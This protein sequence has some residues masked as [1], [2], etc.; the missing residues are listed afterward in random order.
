MKSSLS[1]PLILFGLLAAILVLAIAPDP[2]AAIGGLVLANAG[3]IEIE[4]LKKALTDQGAA[5]KEYFEKQMTMMQEL[6]VRQLDVE[7]KLAR[8]PMTGAADFSGNGIGELTKMIIGSSGL[9]AFQK[10]DTPSVS[11]KVPAHLFKTA[12]ANAVGQNQPLV[13]AD[14]QPGIVF[15]PQR[16]FTIR[17]LFAQIPT[18]SNLVEFCRELTFTNAAAPQYDSSSPTPHAEGAPKAESGMTFELDSEAVITVAHWIPASRQVLADAPQL[19]QH[20]GQR[21]LYGLKL[22]E[23]DEL[24]NSA[25]A[26]G[27][28]NGLINQ[29]AAFTGGA[30]NQSKIDT[31]AKAI[32]QLILTDYEPSGFILNPGDWWSIL[33]LKDSQGR[34]L[35]GDPGAMREPRLWGLPVVATPTMAAGGF[36]AL[37][38]MRAGFI[39]DREDAVIR[40]SEHHADF[41]IKN[42]V[43]ILCEERL[44]LVIQRTGALVYGSLNFA[45]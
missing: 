11:I 17:D 14:R 12:V 44:A 33:M 19:E 23:E 39:A 10:G 7:Q 37:D 9:A 43:A 25:G 38:A 5:V 20:V 2:A 1:Y 35:F 41:F 4:V 28:L 13:P 27:E 34:Y 18:G 15:G 8:K 29:A 6:K 3:G 36:L 40:I 42:L 22:E 32:V 24:L 45:G 16:R 26:N 31:L 30:T 21:L